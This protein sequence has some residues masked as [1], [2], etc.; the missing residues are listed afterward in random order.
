[1]AAA[2]LVTHK[3]TSMHVTLLT[4]VRTMVRADSDPVRQSL[5]GALRQ[6]S[7]MV[8]AICWLHRRL[9][10]TKAS[11]ILVAAYGLKSWLAIFE[12]RNRSPRL[13]TIAVH[14]NAK[15]RVTQVAAA[16]G[17]DHVNYLRTGM[18][19]LLRLSNI[20]LLLNLL[21]S[22]RSLS[23]CFGLIHRINRRHDFLV[24]CRIA[25]LLGCYARSKHLLSG[26][27]P[28]GVLVSSDSNPEEVGLVAAAKS[29]SIATIFASHAYTTSVSPRLSFNL[30]ILEGE[31]A[32]EGYRRKGGVSG[33]IFLGGV[34]GASKP[35]QPRRLERAA[36]LIGI[37]PPKVVNWPVFA[38]MIDDCRLR[39]G[40]RQIII[41]WHPSMIGY[42]RLADVLP[43]F[44]GIVET[45]KTAGLYEVASQCDWAIADAGSNVHL[46]V[47]KLG[48]PTIAVARIGILPQSEADIYGFVANRI[49]FP[50]VSSLRNLPVDEAV[51]FYSGE[52]ADRFRVY[53]EGYLKPE[54]VM[55]ATLRET[56]R[57]LLGEPNSAFRLVAG[58]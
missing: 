6:T 3:C 32:V 38:D 22:P 33:T 57:T 37:F 58:E 53:D 49:V 29:L 55:T 9:G 14:A 30:S 11:S 51:S 24:S 4:A 44:S 27:R 41:R 21:Q 43:N 47:L 18:S 35:M 36:P 2:P 46:Q 23:R 42:T 52:W 54:T 40:A 1:M 31:A 50:P 45:L 13:V 5:F 16:Y 25:G 10:Q 28:V 12:G 17:E 34:E 15:R 20:L 8:R 7:A 19:A 56:L 48:I 39:F 26:L